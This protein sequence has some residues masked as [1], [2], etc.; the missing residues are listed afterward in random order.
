MREEE[1]IAFRSPVVQAN[2]G[3]C[4]Q[5][6]QMCVLPCALCNHPKRQAQLRVERERELLKL[7]KK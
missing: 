4:P 1:K 3:R 2:V 6:G 5:C 7:Q